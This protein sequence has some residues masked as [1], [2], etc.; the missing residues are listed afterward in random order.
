MMLVVEYLFLER[1]DAGQSMLKM[2]GVDEDQYLKYIDFEYRMEQSMKLTKKIKFHGFIE[3][4]IHDSGVDLRL[5]HECMSEY[6]GHVFDPHT[7]LQRPDRQTMPRSMKGD[8][9][10]QSNHTSCNHAE[11]TFRVVQNTIPK[12]QAFKWH[13]R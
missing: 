10:V 7:P 4:H 13:C 1:K 9:L 12:K 3:F 11:D 2:I 5:L 8:P 6:F